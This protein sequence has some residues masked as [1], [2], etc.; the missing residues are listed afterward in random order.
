MLYLSFFLLAATL[1]VKFTVYLHF[2]IYIITPQSPVPLT[3]AHSHRPSEASGLTSDPWWVAVGDGWSIM[4][5]VAVK[6]AA[7]L[8]LSITVATGCVCL[9][10][11][12]WKRESVCACVN[13]SVGVCACMHAF[14]YMVV[15]MWSTAAWM[16]LCQ[17]ECQCS[18]WG[19]RVELT[20]EPATAQRR[21]RRPGHYATRP[22]FIKRR[23]GC[24]PRIRSP[25]CI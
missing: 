9:G 22:V 15:C 11:W 19:R 24:W 14:L 7:W 23:L 2:E 17:R 18:L 6:S 13:S 10:G 3:H 25:L 4:A 20:G 21:R 1:K 16:Q 8:E 12:V 5:A